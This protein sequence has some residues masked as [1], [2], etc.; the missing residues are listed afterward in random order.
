[1]IYKYTDKL[2]KEYAKFI[3]R[4]FNSLNR[5]LQAL[6]FDELNTNQGYKAVSERT[7]KTYKKVYD[8]LIDI[9]ILLALHSFEQSCDK[10]IEKKGAKITYYVGKKDGF[11]KKKTFD[12]AEYVAHYLNSNNY[13]TKYVFENEYERKLSR[14]TESIVMAKNKPE[15]K[16]EV[17]KAL[18]YWNV[19]AKQAGDNITI[20]AY[21]EGFAASGIKKVIWVSQEDRRVCVDCEANDGK[22]FEI[23]K[24]SIPLHYNCRCYFK[25]YKE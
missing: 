17:D 16:K 8:E 21:R 22:I 4:A 5:E 11:R 2:Y 13:V 20:E 14:A 1:M 9:L 10:I 25:P 7:R 23:D 19:Q 3:V 6:G 15:I 18:K 24:I 12:A